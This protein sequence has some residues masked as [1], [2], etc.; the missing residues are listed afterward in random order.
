MVLPVPFGP[1]MQSI[2]SFQSISG[3]KYP[4]AHELYFK[5]LAV[6]KC[7]IGSYRA[8]IIHI[9]SFMPSPEVSLA[10][11]GGDSQTMDYKGAIL[12]NA[13]STSQDM[14]EIYFVDEE[15]EA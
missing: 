6:D 15:E 10:L 9:S 14:V 2:F 4:K 8:C 3:D 12:T 7:E 5:A 11:Q 13:C 1:F